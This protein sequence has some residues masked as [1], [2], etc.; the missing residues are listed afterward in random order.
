MDAIKA[1]LKIINSGKSA[2]TYNIGND[3]PEV[4]ALELINIFSLVLGQNVNYKLVEYSDFY[5]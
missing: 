2:Q 5:P 4:S 1:I 3:N